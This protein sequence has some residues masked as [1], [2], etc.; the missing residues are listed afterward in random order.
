M[1]PTVR[2]ALLGCLCTLFLAG[3]ARLPLKSGPSPAA[4]QGEN[5]ERIP[6][7]QAG[8]LHWLLEWAE[9]PD[10]NAI[11]TLEERGA[12]VLQVLPEGGMIVSAPDGMDWRGLEFTW[13]GLLTRWHKL[14]PLLKEGMSEF[15]V[16]LHPDVDPGEGMALVLQMGFHLL[17]HPDLPGDQIWIRG[18]AELLGDLADWDEVSFVYPA[19]D[20]FG[21]GEPVHVCSRSYA[22][23]TT[24]PQLI[25]RVG[26]GWDGPGL[27]AAALSYT[28]GPLTEKLS[29]D[30]IR[31]EIERALAEWSR[32]VRTIFTKGTNPAA[33]R[34]LHFLFGSR[35]HGDDFPFDGP[36][37]VLAHAFYPSP[38]NP[39]PIA[40]DLH[41]DGDEAWRNGVDV[42]LF[43][44]ALHELG[45]ALGLAHSDAPGDV[46]YPFYRRASQL[47]PGDIAAIRTLYASGATPLALLLGATPDKTT[48]SV[49]VLTGSAEGGA[50]PYSIRWSSDRGGGGTLRTTGAFQF[51]VPLLAG[52]NIVTIEAED[53]AGARASRSVA[54]SRE[55]VSETA[56]ALRIT[57]PAA[58]GTF[59]ST[60]RT[61]VV[62][63]TAS[64][65]SGI[66][67]VTWA[68]SRGGSGVAMGTGNW[69]TQPIALAEGVNNISIAA[70][71]VS[72]AAAAAGLTVQY[73]SET[74]DTT[75]PSLRI[76]SPS[77]STFLTSAAAVAVSGSAADSSG[78]AAVTWTTNLGLTGDAAGTTSWTASVPLSY[79]NNAIT[80]R[81]RDAA[82]NTS[83]RTLLVTRR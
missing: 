32:H 51:D 15:L 38:P 64:H 20:A 73:R 25:A 4:D 42:D 44:V 77:S 17:W 19:P 16:E 56:P 13:R 47:S 11:R 58:G 6:R 2:L 5:P 67:R 81:A 60:S 14:S 54:V 27:G 68:N 43:S 12:R 53:S 46:M 8:R 31:L 69:E 78:V 22:S 28:F 34:N 70:L 63:G 37:R 26:E 29:A 82:G 50:G 45:H 49:L 59:V 48:D 41:F 21:Q 10:A 40:G 7:R 65:A 33:A 23:G 71:S 74:R 75:A 9:N 57:A 18:A 52:R 72:G 76:T 80:I 79:G 39:E 36:S 66:S 1:S 24:I 55:S 83:W 62:R 30:T 35:S 61:V 3:Q